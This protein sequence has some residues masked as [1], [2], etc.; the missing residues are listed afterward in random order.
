[1]SLCILVAV[2]SGAVLFIPCCVTV[3]YKNVYN[4]HVQIS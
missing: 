2:V 4:S 1:M 3:G